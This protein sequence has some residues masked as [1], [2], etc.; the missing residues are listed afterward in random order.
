MTIELTSQLKA[1][2][3]NTV[4]RYATIWRLVRL[5]G[6]IFRFSDH[7]TDI[8]YKGQ[9][10]KAAIGFSVSA[11]QQ[12]SG[13]SESNK[14]G[15]GILIPFIDSA[16]EIDGFTESDIRGGKYRSASVTEKLIDW[17]YPWAEELYLTR[18]TI[19]DIM[20]DGFGWKVELISQSKFLRLPVGKVYNRNCRHNFGSK[21]HHRASNGT[22][23]T[24]FNPGCGEPL[25]GNMVGGAPYNGKKIQQ[26]TTITTAHH[27]Q[28]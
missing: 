28:G 17:Q 5:D 22:T 24:K 8:T 1:I 2:N 7:N 21:H 19:A 9:L 16:Y 14:T 10:Y 15:T 12:V 26:T 18:Y 3:E 13:M 25:G 20:N 4:H 27:N 23:L 11:T 6:T